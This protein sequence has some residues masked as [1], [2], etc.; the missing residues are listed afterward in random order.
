MN[1]NFPRSTLRETER[2]TCRELARISVLSVFLQPC[3]SAFI[4]ILGNAMHVELINQFFVE[5]EFLI[6]FQVYL[7]QRR[8][9]GP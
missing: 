8:H 5:F 7:K 1:V 4:L 6:A 2:D 9:D 3:P